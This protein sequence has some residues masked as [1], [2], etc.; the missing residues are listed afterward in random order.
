[1]NNRKS[2]RLPPENEGQH[3]TGQI[4]M[5]NP[6]AHSLSDRLIGFFWRSPATNVGERCRRRVV[7]HLI[8]Y[9]FFL[10]VLAYLDRVNVSV[11]ALGMKLPLSE[12]GLN[13]DKEIIGIGSGMFFWGY[14]ILEIPST[15]TVVKWGAR[16]VFVRILFL[17]GLA[18]MLIGGIGT[19]WMEQMLGWVSTDPKIQ[20][21]VLRF[22][23]GF[24]EG[25]FF[26]S[27]IVYL[28]L[29]FRPEDR[30][31]AIGSFMA[32]I[33]LSNIF[34]NPISGFVLENVHWFG[35]PGWRWVFIL[36]GILPMVAAF[37]TI[38]LL[39]D[40]PE[41]AHWLR[42]DEKKWLTGEL[43]REHAATQSHGHWDWLQHAGI[44]LLFTLAYF[45]MNVATYGLQFFMP[46]IIQSLLSSSAF[47]AT[48][49]TAGPFLVAFIG[50]QVNAWHSDKTRERIWHTAG[51]MLVFSF[52][53]MCAAAV[54]RHPVIA[55]LMM[56]FVMAPFLWAW[57]PSFWPM[58]RT[59]M[60]ATAAASAVGFINMIGNLGGGVGSYIVGKVSGEAMAL[61]ILALMPVLS[62]ITI[63]AIG[64]LRRQHFATAAVPVPLEMPIP[65]ERDE[66]IQAAPAVEGIRPASEAITAPHK[67]D[68]LG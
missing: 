16:W 3:P 6:S 26:P 2:N 22:M 57:L 28:S 64:R 10:Y 23:L 68:E 37:T 61:F 63:I 40:R 19:P 18:C 35:L 39:P 9:L 66:R 30:A 49:V 21:Y 8:P 56:T 59:L 58:P 62:A 47:W 20:F 48:A 44:V 7:L 54:F 15:L 36:Q 32:A 65:P 12:G 4:T 5:S 29:W 52:G 17:W 41:Q 1:M 60:G 34:G 51:I 14:W 53:L 25:G 46:A 43:D 42:D 13:F 50:M 24:F 45:C 11:A 67:S 31:K 55:L 38:F 27:V 33:P